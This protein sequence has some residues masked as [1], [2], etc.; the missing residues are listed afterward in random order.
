MENRPRPR[1]RHGV[2]RGERHLRHGV[3]GLS[4]RSRFHDGC[5]EDPGLGPDAPCDERFHDDDHEEPDFD[6]QTLNDERIHDE[7]YWLIRLNLHAYRHVRDY[8]SGH[9][10]GRLSGHLCSHE[11]DHVSGHA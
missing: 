11:S 9:A 4:L 7:R 10:S 8:L 2:Q 5:L 6:R 1:V 3:G